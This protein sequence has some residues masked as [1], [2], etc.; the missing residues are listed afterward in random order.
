M[1]TKYFFLIFAI[2]SFLFSSCS[3][4]SNEFPKQESDSNDK[5]DI[6]KSDTLLLKIGYKISEYEEPLFKSRA[7]SNSN[8]LIGI[9]IMNE[10]SA[11]RLPYACGVFDDVEE[12]IFKFV[13]GNKYQ[14]M[15]NYYPNAKKIVYKN[16]NG[17][18]GLP[19]WDMY[20]LTEY[21]INQAY[22]YTGSGS[23][24]NRGA[25]LSELMSN[26]VQTTSSPDVRD[27]VRGLTVRYLG[28]TELITI[29]EDT[30]ISVPL[31]LYM[32]GITLNVGNFSEGSL[33]LSIDYGVKQEWTFK[34]GDDMSV[35]FQIPGRYICLDGHELWGNAYQGENMTLF[36]TDKNNETFLLASKFIPY[37]KC[38]VNHVFTFDLMEREDGS[39]GIKMPDDNMTDEE[40]EFD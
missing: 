30:K 18:Y 4:G 23:E 15:M 35:I 28:Y 21:T 29:K 10:T 38:G 20:G 9:Q 13:K 27:A 1:K 36:Y 8:D 24:G 37:E 11:T 17:T 19:F 26:Y 31:E 7:E 25:V 14:I 5:E 33:R 16:S 3:N 2:F 6:A 34:P 40:T 32:K 39:I 22:Y 12:L